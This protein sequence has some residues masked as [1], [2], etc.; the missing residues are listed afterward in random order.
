MSERR[1]TEDFLLQMIQEMLLFRL[2]FAMLVQSRQQKSVGP[3]MLDHNIMSLDN[4]W[5]LAFLH[6]KSYTD[7][8]WVFYFFLHASPND[9]L[10]HESYVPSHA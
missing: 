7:I 1:L 10:H 6:H 9:F 5:H 3:A 8:C 2:L 4:H